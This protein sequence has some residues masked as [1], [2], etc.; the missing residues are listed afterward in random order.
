MIRSDIIDTLIGTAFMA[1]LSKKREKDTNN[2]T[3]K[4]SSS[5]HYGKIFSGDCSTEHHAIFNGFFFWHT[6]FF[7]FS[8]WD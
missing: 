6:V 4:K 8:F 7:F 3:P 1:G 5:A 2:M